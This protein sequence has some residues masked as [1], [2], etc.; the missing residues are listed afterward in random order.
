MNEVGP[1]QTFLLFDRISYVKIIKN[2]LCEH[3]FNLQYEVN[4]QT[5]VFIIDTLL[6]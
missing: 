2:D 4:V 3:Y 6:R 5:H 1:C